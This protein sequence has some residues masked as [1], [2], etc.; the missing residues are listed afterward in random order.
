[1][2][3]LK[4]EN[5]ILR[6]EN[7]LLTDHAEEALLLRTIAEVAGW[8]DDPA[9]LLGEVLERISVLRDIPLCACGYIQDSAV[10]FPWCY[11]SFSP[12]EHRARLKVPR[13]FIQK[14]GVRNGLV[15]SLP[16]RGYR[17][18]LFEQDF[19]ARS[20]FLLPF[21]THR[22]EKGFFL[23]GSDQS[24][25]KWSG[26]QVFLRQA[27]DMVAARLD[28]ID[29]SGE[30]Q[31]INHELD[32]RVKQRTE[33]LQQ[34]NR[35]LNRLQVLLENVINSMPS[36][37]I[38]LD[39]E[40]NILQWNHEAERMSGCAAEE[41][42]GK[43]LKQAF[44]QLSKR[45]KELGFD[46][47]AGEVREYRRLPL[48]TAD[49]RQMLTDMTI[50]PL[51]GNDGAVIR[52]DD[53][54]DR[55]QLEEIMVEAEKMLSLGG[56]AAG[57]AHEINNPLAGILQSLQVVRNRLSPAWSENRQ[58]AAACG[59]SLEAVLAFLE[60]RNILVMLDNATD[61]GRRA[62]GIVDNMLNFSRKS[63]SKQAP[64]DLA[65][66]L[67]RTLELLSQDYDLEKGYDFRKIE[68]RREIEPNLPQVRCEETKIQQVLLN[69]LRNGAQAMGQSAAE[70]PSRFTLKLSKRG[71][72][73]QLEIR[74]NG[75]G[76]EPE[77]CRRIF[78]PFFT[79]KGVRGTGLGLSVS[80]FI[81]TE[82]H[83]GELRVESTPGK[84]SS[85]FIRLP[86]GG[87]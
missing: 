82:Q 49:G 47:A 37:L 22:I 61:N 20:L 71:K 18:E 80:Y 73:L 48:G 53:I 29:L 31:R 15:L 24:S 64:H 56:L 86:L 57:M 60:K 36:L 14:G 66:L 16:T 51:R 76:M 30:L 87:S 74:D 39:A 1:M 3:S 58:A 8:S 70:R 83:G 68:I 46:I 25:R 75:P 35:E 63:E 23:F 81:I 41:A 42:R 5:R 2:E 4:A 32:Q 21:S 54:G 79:T 19:T 28:R 33:E 26:P 34:S 59:I 84:G 45:L 85:F 50:Y 40:W 12:K 17:F 11:A 69:I 72:M 77:I 55:V 44:P 9:N 67:E 38:G 52:V 62:A 10:E 7:L 65:V 13:T 27:V 78:E 6:E 43:P